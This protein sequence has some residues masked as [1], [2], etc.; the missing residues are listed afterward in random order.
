MGDLDTFSL[1]IDT[2]AI[3][4]IIPIVIFFHKMNANL[5]AQKEVL[6]DIKVFLKQARMES[7]KEHKEL[8]KDIQ[9][10]RRENA[11][12]HSNFQSELAVLKERK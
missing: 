3:G 10:F 2:I 11:E 6:E 1:I 4:I 5:E 9:D 12:G 8:L 7:T